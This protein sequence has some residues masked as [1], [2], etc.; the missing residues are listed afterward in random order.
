MLDIDEKTYCD[1]YAKTFRTEDCSI[2][3]KMYL[4][5]SDYKTKGYKDY[6]YK[7]CGKMNIRSLEY[8][9]KVVEL[10]SFTKASETVK[11]GEKGARVNFISP[12]IIITPLAND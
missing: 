11:W 1:N 8:F 9:I 5:C 2:D 12:G 10:N 7:E 6:K 4:K 3:Y